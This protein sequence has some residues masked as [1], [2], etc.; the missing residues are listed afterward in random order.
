M[1]VYREHFLKGI[2]RNVFKKDAT[3]WERIRKKFAIGLFHR[4]ADSVPAYKNFLKDHSV[5]PD[6]IKT[7]ED[8]LHVPTISKD[9]YLKN[10][11]LKSLVRGGKINHRFTFTSTSGSTGEPYYFPRNW[12]LDQ[13]SSIVHELFLRQAVFQNVPVL[14]IDGFSMGVW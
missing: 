3:Y 6:K 1:E 5:A 8:F 2:V 4:V 10:Y 7:F 13:E 14:I 12:Q 9:N 11:P